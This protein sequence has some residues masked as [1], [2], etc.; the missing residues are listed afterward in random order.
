MLMFVR[1]R[2]ARRT[3]VRSAR[4]SKVWAGAQIGLTQMAAGQ[5]AFNT[6]ESEADLESQGKPTIA[7]IRGQ[8]LVQTD[9]SAEVPEDKCNVGFGIALLDARA[10]AAGAGSLPGP[11]TNIEFPWMWWHSSVIA[12]QTTVGLEQVLSNFDRIEVDGKAMRK[13][14]P[15]H[16]LVL[17]AEVLAITG[18][19]D[20]EY[21]GAL[22]ILL[23]PS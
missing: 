16:L 10:V 8:I 13:A 11:L 23:M 3:A 19:S 12:V 21:F 5:V 20:I 2:F 7:R 17:V 18:T 9:F 6:L 22:R 1:N 4:R 15:G 14:A